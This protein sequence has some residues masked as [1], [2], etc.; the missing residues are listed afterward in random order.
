MSQLFWNRVCSSGH[1]LVDIR[2]KD[3]KRRSNLRE[4]SKSDK[5]MSPDEKRKVFLKLHKLFGH[6]SADRLQRLIQSSGNE[7]KDCFTILLQ[8]V[9]DCE[10]CQKYK[11]TKSKPAV[12]LLMAS[13]YNCQQ[14]DKGYRG[15]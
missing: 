5:N 15:K 10:I 14:I 12:G 1:Y 11:R 9:Y 13:E 4:S 8:I 7:D 6:A 2:D 3:T